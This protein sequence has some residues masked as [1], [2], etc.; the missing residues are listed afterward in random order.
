MHDL[1]AHFR[2]EFLNRLDEIILFKPLTRDNIGGIISLLIED[3]NKRLADKE[4]SIS[5]TERAKEFIVENG[6]DPY[7]AQGRLRDI[8]RKCGDFGGKIDSVGRCPGRRYD[9]DRPD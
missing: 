2:P 1:R 5:L 8:C 4:L 6:Y 7:T 3:V 9:T